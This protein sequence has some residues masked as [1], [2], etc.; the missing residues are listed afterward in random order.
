[1]N[2]QMSSLYG[3]YQYKPISVSELQLTK[4]LY[5]TRQDPRF[6]EI[7]TEFVRDFWF[8]LEPHTLNKRLKKNK[9]QGVFKAIISTILANCDTATE[10]L[11][12]RFKKWSVTVLSGVKS[13]KQIKL[14]YNSKDVRPGGFTEKK[15]KQNAI[16]T[17]LDAG[18][19]FSDLPFNKG[20]PKNILS[21]KENLKLSKVEKIKI[22]LANSL[23]L[24]A[25]HLN[26]DELAKKINSNT[27][28]VSKIL[29]NKFENIKVETMMGVEA[30]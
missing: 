2:S 4:D 27:T 8:I 19:Y 15:I 3:Q 12:I 23:K 16:Q 26:N 14:F 21:L 13:P 25:L 6:L 5:L 17:F 10:E 24:Q 1:M 30:V 7:V 29:N 11:E 20:I 28:T 9:E 22:I 18:Y